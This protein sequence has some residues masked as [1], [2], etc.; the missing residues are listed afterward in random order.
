MNCSIVIRAYN[1][2][3]HVGR[4]LEGVTH[5]TIQDA[6]I[7]LVDSGSTDNTVA[8]AESFGA[9][10]VK[11]PSAEFTFGR[12]LNF[13]VQ[14][15]RRELVVIASAHVYPV[16]PD[17]LECLLRPFTNEETA[18]VYGKQRGLETSKFSEHQIFRQWFPDADVQRQD[19]PF[20]NNANAAIRRSLWEE[21]PYDETLT[22]LE[23][24]AWAKWAQGAGYALS[25]AAH[26]EVIHVHNETPRGIYNRYCR[27]AMAFKRI[28]PESHFN[29]Y[30][31]ARLTTT[32]ILSDLSHAGRERAFWRH[33]ASIFWFRFNQFWGTYQGYRRSGPVT[34]QLRQTFYY[35]HWNAGKPDE[36]DIE[37]IRYNR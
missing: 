12:S 28:F 31:F 34:Q 14:A 26:A 1:E 22:G 5:Q 37:P 17:W 20:C 25:Y 10:V 3:R 35:P 33:L 23:D 11:I 27:E 24:L 2:E 19:S 16:Y 4:L 13:G 29:V 32:N 7:I 9:Q 18:L 6:E 21:H 30:D 8:I 15:A 36:R